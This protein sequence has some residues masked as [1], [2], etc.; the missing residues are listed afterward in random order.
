[1]VYLEN[2][3]MEWKG[4]NGI[5]NLLGIVKLSQTDRD[6]GCKVP[7]TVTKIVCGL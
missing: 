4:M 3:S 1:M 5:L 6:L 2:K 7:S